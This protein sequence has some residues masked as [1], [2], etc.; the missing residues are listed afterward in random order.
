MKRLIFTTGLPRMGKTTVL[1]RTAEK[2]K[3]KGYKLGGMIS[4]EIREANTRV[5]FEIIDYASRRKGWLAHI[6]QPKGP[7]IGKYRVNLHDLNSI[8]VTA[9]LNALKHE[10]IVLIDEIGPMELFSDF[11]KDVL[12]KALKSSKPVLGT[13]HFHAQNQLIRQIKS[14][15]DVDIIEVTLENRNDLPILIV[16]K[17]INLSACAY[18]KT[19]EG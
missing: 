1:T 15:K 2:L 5:G 3:V 17:V 6:R 8:G 14:R 19:R 12:H 11:F 7:R 10:D 4:Q 18:E 16:D 13:I 9:I